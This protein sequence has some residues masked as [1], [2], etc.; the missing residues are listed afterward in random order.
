MIMQLTENY[1]ERTLDGVQAIVKVK[2]HRNY[3]DQQYLTIQDK[4]DRRRGDGIQMI[5]LAGG[6]TEILPSGIPETSL[7]AVYR[8][9]SMQEIGLEIDIKMFKFFG[10]Y[11]KLRDGGKFNYNHLYVVELDY[12]PGE[13]ITKDPNEVSKIHKRK[14]HEIIHLAQMNR[15]HEG[16]IRLMF[17]FLNGNNTGSLNDPVTFKSYT[18]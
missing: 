2:S 14:L 6:G 12:D 17:N 7:E 18:F 4:D 5:G 11:L 16:S 9:V 10:T 1:R 3:L 13:L 8:E 15:I